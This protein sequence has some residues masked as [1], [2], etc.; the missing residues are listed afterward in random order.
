MDGVYFSTLANLAPCPGNQLTVT[1][2]GYPITYTVPTNA[3]LSMVAT[4]LAASDQCRDQCHPGQSLVYGDR[5]ELQ[6][7][8]TNPLTVPFYVADT[9]RRIPPAFPIASTPCRILFH[10]G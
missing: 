3:T 4:G 9:P 10:P 7:I 2:N 5:I 1:L 6:S 8:A